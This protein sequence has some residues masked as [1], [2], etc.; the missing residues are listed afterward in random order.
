VLNGFNGDRQTI[1]RMAPQLQRALVVDANAQSASFLNDL[2]REVAR[3]RVWT[4]V[5][6]DRAMKQAATSDPQ[7]IF[8]YH[9]AGVLDGLAFTRRLRR[10]AE[11]CRQAPVILITE[12]AT[13]ATILA[14]RDAGVHEFLRKPFTLK[15]LLRRLEAVT[16]RSRDWIEAA[17]YVGPDRRRFNSGDYTG[18]LK[19]ASDAQP[20]HDEAEL[21][22][23]LRILR[24]A[25]AAVD[26]DPGQAV[27]ALLA[28][29]AIIQKLAAKTGDASLQPAAHA[30]H[31]KLSAACAGG[32]IPSG[33]D[34][35]PL[36]G[37]LLAQLRDEPARPVAA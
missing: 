27:R 20:A 2:L 6:A 1:E 10:S 33:R 28:Q 7:V 3:G 32:Q 35:A 13:A 18:P 22:Q 17:G 34:L 8:V 11:A 30:F 21:Q 19:R 14:A 36:A 9:Q 12:D 16:L 5:T 15:D 29:S 25:L 37:A 4:A 26:R 24:G 31:R 23:A